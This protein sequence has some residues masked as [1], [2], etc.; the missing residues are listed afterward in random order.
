L[1]PVKQAPPI[2]SMASSSTISGRRTAHRCLVH[3][4]QSAWA[5]AELGWNSRKGDSASQ[6][7][8]AAENLVRQLPGD[9]NALGKIKLEAAL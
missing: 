7:L 4:D 3:I 1:F 2:F 6:P 8:T 5:A 9:D